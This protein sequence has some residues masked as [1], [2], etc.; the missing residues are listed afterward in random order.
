MARPETLQDVIATLLETDPADVHPDLTFAGT[1]LQGSLA[2]TRLYTAIEQQ[3]GMACQAAY[4]AC[5]YGELQ[6]AIDGTAPAVT[7]TQAA[8]APP[9]PEQH[10]QHNG[11]TPSIACGIDIEMVENLP[12]VPDYWSDAFY[13][14]T[15]T[16]A[17]I[18]YCLLQDQPVVHFAARWCAKE[19]LKKCDPA[20]LQADLRTLEVRLSASGAPYLCAVADGHS[21]PL[22]FAV[23]LSHT[24]QAAVA[25]VVKVPEAP[26]ARSAV[27]PTVLPAVTAPPAA[28]ADGGSRWHSAWLPLL[29]GSS[30]LGLALWALVRTW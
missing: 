2:R 22:P 10:V 25:I 7:A 1:R 15:F 17:E 14:A 3:L 29:M 5:T 30:A 23:S 8:A 4:T 11:A 21:T 13:S 18:A 12:A 26:S 24:T 20:Y 27:P 6:A 19:A 28:S 16:P 9:A